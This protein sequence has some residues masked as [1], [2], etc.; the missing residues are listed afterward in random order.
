MASAT[1]AASR[2]LVERRRAERKLLVARRA[3][4]RL[5]NA[6]LPVRRSER[7]R[8]R[9]SSVLDV[10]P[11][12]LWVIIFNYVL[13]SGTFA[14]AVAGRALICSLSSSW[15][16]F[17][18]AWPPFWTRILITSRTSADDLLVAVRRAGSLKLH[19]RVSLHACTWV[20]W[21]DCSARVR[22]SLRALIPFTP[23]LL[24]ARVCTNFA[25]IFLQVRD[26]FAHFSSLSLEEFSVHFGFRPANAWPS[27]SAP[28]SPW[29]GG[30][31][32]SLRVLDLSSTT[33]SF[34]DISLREL[35]V[36]RLRGVA[37]GVTIEFAD[38]ARIVADAPYLEEIQL[39]RALVWGLSDH[40]SVLVPSVTVTALSLSFDSDGTVLSL[41]GRLRLPNLAALT[42]DITSCGNVDA[43]VSLASLLLSVTSLTIRHSNGHRHLLGLFD[44]TPLFP[45]FPRLTTLDIRH[46][47]RSVFL[48]LLALSRSSLYDGL[49]FVLPGLHTLYLPVVRAEDAKSFLELH[50]AT[51]AAMGGIRSLHLGTRLTIFC[52]CVYSSWALADTSLPAM[53]F[54][55]YLP[56]ELVFLIFSMALGHPNCT[57][58]RALPYCQLRA[59]LCSVSQS[60]LKYVIGSPF[61]WSL[62]RI[63]SRTSPE[64]ISALISRS[65]SAPLH[66]HLDFQFSAGCASSAILARASLLLPC[67]WRTSHMRI[68]VHRSDTMD[69]IHGLFVDT[70]APR[71]RVFFLRM[72][73]NP[74]KYYGP[75]STHP[76]RPLLWFRGQHP[77]LEELYLHS[78][79]VPFPR[80]V[81]PALRVLAVSALG[82]S[83]C[84]PVSDLAQVLRNCS[85]L[86]ELRVG[87]IFSPSLPDIMP[88]LS[89]ST[90]TTLQLSSFRDDFSMNE[91]VDAFDFPYMRTLHLF[92]GTE[93][94]VKHAL[95][96]SHLFARV[97]VLVL[98]TQC[99]TPIRYQSLPLFTP[100]FFGSVTFLDLT[101]CGLFVLA[102]LLAASST[103]IVDGRTTVMPNLAVLLLSHV[104]LGLVID[105]ALVHGVDCT[106]PCVLEEIGVSPLPI[107]GR[108]I[109]MV[110]Q[111]IQWLRDRIRCFHL[112][113]PLLRMDLE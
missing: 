9:S 109:A 112:T 77:A 23:R 95:L 108:A 90:I 103:S 51:D 38:F 76:S 84:V 44:A 67:L 46:C 106:S 63:T 65:A 59:V 72:D 20:S 98:D 21:E 47:A 91:V 39:S 33:L 86:S 56:A 80:L 10:L 87:R 69:D 26:I 2:L 68:D 49:T 18:C 85:V 25:I 45:L 27:Y 113:V 42:L 14:S 94:D 48:E 111:D 64:S 100:Q 1:R 52:N 43:V 75:R 55:S 31:F 74:L 40:P 13:G 53:D 81:F 28:G 57:T 16:R 8:L 97:T 61:F 12:E 17:V 15:R 83:F 96:A 92:V 30:V 58:F 34:A 19:L 99:P 60:W 66:L 79:M 88:A 36:L 110:A 93:S 37:L 101:R 105:F 70:S 41:A 24:T 71:L 102:Q 104:P 82:R 32:K 6:S 5:A 89:S 29:F 54:L 50:G 73:I 3:A 11:I 35:R 7:I 4:A 62:I 22:S 78:T 107:R